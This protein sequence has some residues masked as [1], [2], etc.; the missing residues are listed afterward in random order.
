ME[1]KSLEKKNPM[2]CWDIERLRT[3]SKPV[4]ALEEGIVLLHKLVDIA[5]TFYKKAAC[6]LAAPQVGIFKRAFIILSEGQAGE[7]PWQI[8]DQW[9]GFVNPEVIEG[10]GEGLIDYDG[11]LSFPALEGITRRYKRI[12]IAA[13]NCPEPIWLESGDSWVNKAGIPIIGPGPA[14]YFQHEIDHL[15]GKL[16]F[17]RC[18]DM[19]Q[20]GALMAEIEKRKNG[21]QL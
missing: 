11:C 8:T 12:K 5:D 10:Q 17:D 15:D 6:G 9:Q 20:L 13:L 16:F 4:G 14:I 21:K 19:N 7:T 18:S 2:I 1:L 3:K